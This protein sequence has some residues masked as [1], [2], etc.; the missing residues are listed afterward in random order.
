MDRVGEKDGRIVHGYGA[1]PGGGPVK[2]LI[3]DNYDSFV[4]NLAQY[5]GEIADKVV[6]KRNDE[7]DVAGVRELSPDRIVISPGPGNPSN[8]RYFGRCTDILREVSNETPTLGVCLGH[9]GIVHAFGGRIVRA[10]RLRHG[11]TSPIRHDGKGVLRGVK[12][13]FE[14]TRYHSL[15]AE[16]KSL[17]K[18]LEVTA[19]SVDD[20]EIMGVR[21]REF[22]IEGVQFHPESI[23][24]MPGHRIIENFLED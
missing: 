24:T 21:H 16:R 15:V 3:L 22:P 8:A 1:G 20:N 6:V 13:P 17:P 5:V 10:R 4:Y 14:A 19:Q 12:S 7:I 18:S 11:K 9:Q 2:V 23:L